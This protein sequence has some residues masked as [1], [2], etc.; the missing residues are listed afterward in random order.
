VFARSEDFEVRQRW[1]A[2]GGEPADGPLGELTAMTVT[3]PTPKYALLNRLL[4]EE[5]LAPYDFIVTT[6]DDIV[7]PDGF[8]DLFLGIQASLGF[9]LAQPARTPNSHVDHPIVVQQRGV[10]ARRTLFV[11]IGPLVS[12]S[13]TIYKLLLPFDETNSMG[14]GFENVWSYRL[15]EHG[16]S[17]GIVDAV[18]VDH[19]IRKPVEHYQWSDAVADRERYLE[20]NPHLPLEECFRVLEVVGVNR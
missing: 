2:L 5:D 9:D 4:A 12:F 15:R 14:W 8:L 6:D 11:E 3:E 17:Q 1:I 18:P 19:S 20:A 16:R 7:V 10:L 13:R